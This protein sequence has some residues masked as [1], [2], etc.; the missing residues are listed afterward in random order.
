MLTRTLAAFAFVLV[1]SF[2]ATSARAQGTPGFQPGRFFLVDATRPVQSPGCTI[3][4]ELV[5]QGSPQAGVVAHLRER[6]I[7]VCEIHVAPNVRR[8][9]L[10]QTQTS[11]GSLVFRGAARLAD[12]RSSMIELT[13]HRARL[14]LDIVPARVVAQEQIGAARRQLQ[15]IDVGA[16]AGAPANRALSAPEA[17]ASLRE[18]PRAGGMMSCEAYWSGWTYDAQARTCV[19]LGASGCS[20]PFQFATRESCLSAHAS[21]R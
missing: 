18:M 14:C 9:R 12:G 19:E 17:R 5:L 15:S 21:F 20:S 10:Q 7:G 2:S 4:T 3:G 6:V 11:C 1:A 13:D 8:Y 16:I